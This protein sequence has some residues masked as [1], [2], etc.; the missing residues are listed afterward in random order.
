[1]SIRKSNYFFIIGA[2]EDCNCLGMWYYNQS[3][4]NILLNGIMELSEQYTSYTGN[5]IQ[6]TIFF[7]Q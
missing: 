4:L 1:M 2:R 6:T 7:T 3:I 5:C